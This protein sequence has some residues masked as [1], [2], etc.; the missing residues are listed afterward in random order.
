MHYG[1][2]FAKLFLLTSWSLDM[3]YFICTS[4]FN[5]QKLFY[6]NTNYTLYKNAGF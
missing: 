6:V 5:V 2:K 1:T 4:D 3:M